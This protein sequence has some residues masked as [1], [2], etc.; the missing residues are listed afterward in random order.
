MKK[1]NILVIFAVLSILII[2]VSCNPTIKKNTKETK[3]G[4]TLR[5]NLGDMPN[6]IF[7][8]QILKNSEQIV[9]S[10]VYD[11]LIK[12][13]PKNLEIIPSIAKEWLVERD[14]TVYTFFL[15]KTAKFHDDPCF[16]DGK[17]RVITAHDFKYSIEQICRNHIQNNSSLSKQLKNI[18]GFEQFFEKE[19]K[20][21]TS[22]IKGISVYN[23]TILVFS[24]NKSDKMF[25]H[26]LAGTN[27]FVFPKEA[28]EKYGIESN[29][30]SGAFLIKDYKDHTKPILL[31]SNPNYFY[32][33]KQNEKLPFLD[34]VKISFV[35]SARQELALF[36]NDKID[37]LLSIPKD[38]ITPFLDEFIDLFQS[39]PP[40]YMLKQIVDYKANISY[41]VFRANVNNLE[42]NSQGF[43]DFSTVFFKEPEAKQIKLNE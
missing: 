23:D 24:L 8:G 35:T 27:G 4:G 13:N 18:K 28:F 36:K 43:F 9:A 37:I 38:V 31:T 25:I 7:P 6:H 34:T 14:K 17:G 11:G 32:K 42:V 5:I 10:Q 21:I 22:E 41:N 12:Y 33:T 39:N 19:N 30:G 16:T 40:Y 29:V 3:Y 15:N 1:N 20:G 2:S 26:F